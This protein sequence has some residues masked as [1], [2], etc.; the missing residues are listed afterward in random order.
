MN[1]NVALSK[2]KKNKH[3]IIAYALL[4]ILLFSYTIPSAL[5]INQLSTEDLDNSDSQE[6]Q[7]Q[8]SENSNTETNDDQSADDQENEEQHQN[9][10][11]S[12]DPVDSTQQG[13]NT[14]N[15][16]SSQNQTNKTRIVKTNDDQNNQSNQTDIQLFPLNE[17]SASNQNNNT[18]SSDQNTSSHIIIKI[19]DTI[20]NLSEEYTNSIPP[21]TEE[22]FRNKTE[23]TT[24]YIAYYHSIQSKKHVQI[25]PRNKEE[26]S[27]R[28]VR[29]QTR[30][31]QT[32]VSFTIKKLKEK[33]PEIIEPPKNA[34]V[35]K[36]I[37]IKLFSHSTY[38]D[39]YNIS[40]MNFTF[41]VNKTWLD[42]H[43]LTNKSILLIRYHNGTWEILNTT[44]QSENETENTYRATTPGLSTFAIVGS[45]I[46]PEDS[47]DDSIPYIPWFFIV[48]F[49]FGATVVIL[50]VIFKA[51]YIYSEETQEK[52]KKK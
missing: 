35:Y 47:R 51:D 28:T 19:N 42:E 22:I 7:Q 1:F 14:T 39:E 43:N 26:T 33:P 36:Y 41:T 34:E 49:I 5:C 29:F 10:S 27:I 20:T 11:Q 50:V 45:E 16:S 30:T 48:G 31:N 38:I 23:N 4:I 32:T 40:E 9:D 37:E 18:N 2:T 12:D 6:E 15:S 24:E 25:I 8:I 44:Y 3:K 52:K 46:I 21:N 13:S 17:T